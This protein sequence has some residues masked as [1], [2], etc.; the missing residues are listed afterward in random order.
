MAD[1]SGNQVR[2]ELSPLWMIPV[3]FKTDDNKPFCQLLAEKQQVVPVVGCATWVFTNVNAM[4]YYRTQYSAEDLKKVMG[5]ALT[6]LGEAERMSVIDDES[7]LVRSGQEKIGAFLDLVGALSSDQERALVESYRPMLE[8]INNYIVTDANREAYHAWLRSVFRPLLAKLGWTPAAGETDDVRMVRADLVDVLGFAGEDPETIKQATTLARQYLHDPNSVDPTLAASVLNV[9]AVG[10]DTALLEEYLA[11]MPRM[12]SPEQYYN[13][14]RA[15]AEFRGEPLVDR[16]LQLAVSDQVRSQDAPHMIA[17][18]LENSKNQNASWAWVKAHWP[19]VEKKITMSSGA[20][21]V[22]ATRT[23]C[24][25]G[26]RDDVQQFFTQHKVPSA[27]RTLKQAG[28]R[29]NACINYRNQQQG[30][31]AAWLG[32][33]GTAV[34]GQQQ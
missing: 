34:G 19:E 12:K 10:G 33:R 5:A 13:M 8:S 21:I 22:S 1:P 14:G 6:G 31:L 26:Q 20:E 32:Q 16:V 15:L 3:C 30:N 11:A 24:D 25:P 7:A 27:E 2:A 17:R 23:F 4:G 9:A 28:E 18:E 29:V